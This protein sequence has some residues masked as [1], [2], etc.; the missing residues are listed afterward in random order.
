MRNYSSNFKS[1]INQ[2]S[3][4]ELPVMLVTLYHPDISGDDKVRIVADTQDV[5]SNGYIFTAFP[6]KITLPNDIENQVPR[7]SVSI[8]NI[9]KDLMYWIIASNGGEGATVRF[10]QIMRSAPNTIE[11]TITMELF[12]VKATNFE[13]SGELGY[14][15]LFGKPAIR[16]QYRPFN[17]PGLF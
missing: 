9:G 7:A 11:W 13:I 15:N 10:D 4:G 12:N 8:G 5:T 17:A 16:K 3:G 6:V 14:P 2:V 1:S